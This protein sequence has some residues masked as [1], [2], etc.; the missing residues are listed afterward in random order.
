MKTH[1]T[2]ACGLGVLAEPGQLK[3]VADGEKDE[4]IG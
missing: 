1:G 4:G 2:Q 3:L